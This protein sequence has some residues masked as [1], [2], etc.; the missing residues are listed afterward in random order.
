MMMLF[1]GLMH[2]LAHTA[3]IHTITMD[4][5]T[6]FHHDIQIKYTD[7]IGYYNENDFWLDAG[8]K[9]KI[10]WILIAAH[11]SKANERASRTANGRDDAV[12]WS[13]PINLH[14][15]KERARARVSECV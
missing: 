6:Q 15:T 14:T 8:N 4:A 7:R 13:T 3:H 11:E 1:D 5:F 10:G 2:T 9:N 12:D